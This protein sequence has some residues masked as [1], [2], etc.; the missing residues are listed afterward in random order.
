MIYLESPSF[1]PRFNLALEQYVFDELTKANE[2]FMLWQNDNA[3]IVGKYQNTI[4]EINTE[5]VV[6]KEIQVV[7]RLSGG[8]AVYHDRGNLNFTFISDA[9]N[10]EDLNFRVFCEP[11]I[12]ALCQFGV[13]AHLSGRNDITIDGKKISGNAQYIKNGRVMHHGTILFD[14]DLS[15]VTASLKVSKDKI[16]S[17][18][19]K[20]VRSRVTNLKP[21]LPNCITMEEFKKMLKEYMFKEVDG[22]YALSDSDF[23]RI[24]KIKKE[25]YDLWDW[26]YGFSPNYSIVKQRTVKNCGSIQLSMEVVDGQIT[27]FAIRGDFFGSGDPDEL[28]NHIIGR[29]PEACDLREALRGI[30][31]N[32]YCK[33]LSTSELMEIILQ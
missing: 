2:Y 33:N 7:R 8:G 11:V 25:R 27:E 29:R 5:Y 4:E 17:K 18:G 14:S 20:S 23:K 12:K 9:G 16:E 32:Y 31:I 19:I 6:Q 28:S 10:V 22:Q 30:N 1:D 24:E 3:I 13:T 21:Y 26:N 15:K